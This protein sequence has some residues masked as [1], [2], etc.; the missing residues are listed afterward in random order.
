MRFSKCILT[1]SFASVILLTAALAF[2]QTFSAGPLWDEFDLTLDPGHRQE[3]LGPLFYNQQKDTEHTWAI[4][5]L[6]SYTQDPAVRLKEFDL[7]YPILTYDRYGDQYRWQ[8]IQ[9][10][11]FAG[12][13]MDTNDV[14]H[15]ITIFP[16]YWQQRSENT[17]E[18]YTAV[19]PF[20]G[21]IKHHLFRDEIYFVMFPFYSQTRKHDVITDNYV[22]PFFHLRR[23]DGLEGWQ[24]WPFTGHEHKDVTIRT[25]GFGDIETVPGH[26]NRFVL[27]PIFFTHYTGLG[28]PNASFMQGALPFYSIE[29][30]QDRD[31][32]TI[33]W[34]F[35][36]KIDEREKKYR[37]WDAPWP[38]IEFARGEGKTT[39]RVWPFFSQSHNATL[40]DNFYMWPFYK[41]ER[42]HV[43]PLD[44]QRTRILFFL[45][46]DTI[47]KNTETGHTN[48]GIFLWPLFTH[49]HDFNGNERLQIIA[50]LEPFVQ[51]S[52][53][54]PRDYSHLWSVWRAEKNPRMG[55]DSQSLL[56]NLYRRDA[57]PEHKKVSLLFGLF[58][59]QSGPEFRR[60]RLFY[61]P[62]AGRKPS[63]PEFSPLNLEKP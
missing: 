22:Y 3:A 39:S 40:E 55:A 7:L 13:P 56:W 57:T 31:S 36:N 9:L 23:G 2:G 47:V 61:I 48:R 28:T 24:L 51:G 30:S 58:Q 32:T 26:D 5:P 11:A 53:K 29:R 63:K 60:W 37:E 34:P 46:S 59:Y 35:F 17:N 25:N 44:R 4:P 33:L 18:N 41:Y 16:F 38:F 42:A 6:L 19:A 52:H 62:V 12:G 45:Y 27:W 1:V 21:H 8:L 20:Y 50:P 15:R 10:F 54:I 43:D 14:R 49:R